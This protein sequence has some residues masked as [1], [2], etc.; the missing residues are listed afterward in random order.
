MSMDPGA[1]LLRRLPLAIILRAVG[2]EERIAAVW[3]LTDLRLT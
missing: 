3:T 2:A 1:T